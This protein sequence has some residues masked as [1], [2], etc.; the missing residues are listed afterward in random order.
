M[1]SLFSSVAW[2]MEMMDDAPR[3]NFR[4]FPEEK[5]LRL[6]WGSLFHQSWYFFD[7]ESNQGPVWADWDIFVKFLDK[8]CYKNSQNV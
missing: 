8:F 3:A 6:E 5:I 1:L 4:F 7:W 2:R